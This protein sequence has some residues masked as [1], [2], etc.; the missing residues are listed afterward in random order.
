MSQNLQPETWLQ[1]FINKGVSSST[2]LNKQEYSVEFYLSLLPI[3]TTTE[4][5]VALKDLLGITEEQLG[6]VK[7]TPTPDVPPQCNVAA[8]FSEYLEM[9]GLTNMFGNKMKLK[10]AM[11]FRTEMLGE[12]R[13]T[14]NTKQLP[15]LILQKI[16]MCDSKSRTSLFCGNISSDALGNVENLHPVDSFIVLFNC[17][18][19][20]LRQELFSKLAICQMAV[21]LLLP[22]PNNGSVVFMLWALRSIIK[23][24]NSNLAEGESISKEYRITDYNAPV[25]SFLKIGEHKYSKS[26]FI[27]K[28]FSESK[29]DIFFHWNCKGGTAKRYFV[30][31]LLEISCFLPPK[32]N[33]D[34]FYK[35]M[36][37]L[38]NLRGDARKSK[39]QASFIREISSM[40][41]VLLTENCIDETAVKLLTELSTAPWKVVLIFPDLI[42][43]EPFRNKT[44]QDLQ[45]TMR[46]LK[47]NEKN[48][49]QIKSEVHQAISDSLNLSVIE[50]C[51]T[52]GQCIEIARACG[53]DVDEDDKGCGE[54]KILAGTV[55][56]KIRS[57]NITKAKL[58]M[59]P[60]QGSNM[61]HQWAMLD[62]EFY[63]R[64]FQEGTNIESYSK[65]MEVQKKNV[66]KNQIDASRKPTP[67]MKSF[68]EILK[69]TG[70]GSNRT[71]FL[72][73]LKMMLDDYSMQKLPH[74][75]AVYQN[76]RQQLAK[77][78]EENKGKHED[79]DRVMGFKEELKKQND[80]L[81]NASFGLEHLF[82]EMGQMYE[83]RMDDSFS[84][85]KLNQSVR[86][87]ID[88]YPRMVAELMEEGFPV[89]L[90]DG[91][92]SHVP[93]TWVLAII[94]E[95]QHIY[96]ENNKIFVISVLGIQSTGKSTL[97]NTVFGLRFNVSAGRCTRGAYFQL[98]RLDGTLRE[99]T[100][101][102]FILVVD[103]EGLRAPELLYKEKTTKHD[104]E[105]ATFVIGLADLTVINIFGL[106]PGD[107]T[108]ILETVVYALIRMRGVDL[109]LGCYFVH[110][111]VSDSM[112]NTRGKFG[113]QQI[114]DELDKKTKAI[115]INEQCKDKYRSFQD[116]IYF[117]SNTDIAL[118]PGLW[119]G[120]LPMAP[121][122]P[123]YS[124][125]A[126]KLKQTLFK[127]V[128]RR[129]NYCNFMDFEVRVN[130][131]W[132]A[133]LRENYAFS[134]NNTLEVIAYDELD[135]KYAIWSWKLTKQKLKWQ[136]ESKHEI[137][138]CDFQV[139]DIIITGCLKKL[140]DELKAEY[141]VVTAEMKHF[142]EKNERA[143]TLAKWKKITEVRLS[144]MLEEHKEGA[145][146]HCNVLKVNREGR[147]K[148]GLIRQQYR[149]QT[150][151]SITKLIL[152]TQKEEVSSK[153]LEDRFDL[154]WQQWL[155]ELS[156]SARPQLYTT[157]EQIELSIT[158]TL[159]R[160]F[161]AQRG[162]IIQKLGASPL[163]RREAS[164]KVEVLPDEHLDSNKWYRRL[165]AATKSVIKQ[166][167]ECSNVTKEDTHVAKLKTIEY[168]NTSKES[169]ENLLNILSDFSEEA[170]YDVIMELVN[171]IDEFN[172][173]KNDFSFKPMY[174]VD[175]AITVAAYAY[176]KF[177][178]MVEKLQIENDPIQS[179][180]RLKPV[181]FKTFLSQC[182]DASNDKA[183]ADNLCTLLAIY[184]QN[185]LKDSLRIEIVE[186]MKKSSLHF[187]K[188]NYFKVKILESLAEDTIA[189][190][191]KARSSHEEKKIKNEYFKLY[192]VFLNDISESFRYWSELYTKEHCNTC[193]EKET[194]LVK[195]AKLHLETI[196]DSITEAINDLERIY[197]SNIEKSFSE[198]HSDVELMITD[199]ENDHELDVSEES[200]DINTWLQSFQDRVQKV[201]TVD[202]EEMQQM[203]GVEALQDVKFF[204]T[205]FNKDLSKEKRNIMKAFQNP[206]A[207]IAKV[208]E[209]DQPPHILLYDT[210]VG[211]KDQCPF[212]KEQ[213]EYT[214]GNHEGKCHFSEIHRPQCLGTYR[215]TGTQ[216]MVLDTCTALIE[217]DKTFKNVDTDDKPHPYKEFKKIYPTWAISNESPKAG[218]KYWQWFCATFNSQIVD[219]IKCA[220]TSVKDLGW[221]DITG[222]DAIDS[223]YEAYRIKFD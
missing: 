74:L 79:S 169:I 176:I 223:L 50:Q 27:N 138:G 102:D 144:N 96:G 53:I 101:C 100:K 219:W 177:T 143:N 111:N 63:R 90:M 121:V 46:I 168:L 185:A 80:E 45:K 201:I 33:S 175:M 41:F 139:I 152:E 215:W 147:F 161:Q 134:F 153:E 196:I 82:R 22:N 191:E 114:Q 95:L 7:P 209:W 66:R 81:V 158:E 189:K 49:P 29:Q 18:D 43:S 142:F 57:I 148:V 28:I 109:Q 16:F 91:D 194:R 13:S 115:A 124:D 38:S 159:T 182:S 23:S 36:L 132:E 99:E 12:I 136:N 39:K 170:F 140:E 164:L 205:Q 58:E 86:K 83:A 167:T 78:L 174:K 68:L 52:L 51:K 61:W 5:I 210:L 183:A 141:L 122:N 3:A 104:N 133:V 178:Q 70:P 59:L 55:M 202:M 179:L 64:N 72:Y 44:T 26:E 105:I 87:E 188:K 218:P 197:G 25:I 216:K 203:V 88:S 14:S 135:T 77:V 199:C 155:Q 21:P 11:V 97:L 47:I 6:N 187:G 125:A 2:D 24:W 75:N 128:S 160:L 32:D 19:N 89:E 217:S 35:D 117:D 31:G 71:Y 184:I 118:F 103:T 156:Q 190:L 173:S 54:G 208:T 165:Q 211:C 85:R 166:R 222:Q 193:K 195:L 60:L 214:D 92:T 110:Q 112:A 221:N 127:L 8:Q 180:T 145:K 200:I 4:E 151:Q 162:L 181:F 65:S 17:C 1:H 76:T 56:D 37:I 108:S 67:V 42:D 116:V 120:D 213:C 207:E 15:Y 9:L 73:W 149:E 192:T 119:K 20:F 146:K 30:D 107:L 130:K 98:L 163:T 171:A 94:R 186:D 150:H 10:D 48:D 198:N 154:H 84:Q 123:G 129:L 93:K 40:S 206:D 34:V 157:N 137:N 172:G 131:L 126:C 220:P 106:V 62:K 204:S 113:R 212:C 69:K